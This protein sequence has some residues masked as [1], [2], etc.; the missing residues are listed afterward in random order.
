MRSFAVGGLRV[1]VFGGWGEIG[2]NQLLLEAG[3]E[4]ILLD[5]GRPFGRWKEYFTEFLAPRSAL[6][7]RDLLALGLLPRLRGLYRD[8]P[9]DTLFPTALERQLLD[10]APDAGH[11]QGLLLSH[12]HLDH[13]G[14]I[15]YLRADLPIYTTPET[16][17]ILKAMQD[18]GQAELDGEGVYIRL[19]RVEK[20]KEEEEEEKEEEG[21]EQ[22]KSVL[23]ADRWASYLRRP[24]RCLGGLPQG[25][26]E[27]SPA[28]RKG[29]E[30]H[31]WEAVD[32]PFQVGGFRVRAF[33]VDH[34]VPGAVAFAVETAEGLV[35][36]TGDLRFHGR[37]GSRA[38][39]FLR[40]LEGQKV[41]LLI[42]EGT[43]LG[44]P[45]GSRTEGAVKAALHEEIQKH[46]G[47]PVAVDFAPRN[48]ER[49]ESCLEV[50]RD[51]GR[52]L[53]V[54]PKD[55][56]LL[57]GLSEVDP[58]YKDVLGGVRVLQE[59]KA[60]TPGWE[61]RLKK[62][63]G[64]RRVTIEEVAKAPGSF[65]LALGFYEINRLLD[66]RLHIGPEP[67][68]LYIFSNSYW[69]DQEQILDLRVL[70]RW[71]SEL[72]FR[73]LPESLRG[74]PKDPMGV[75]NPYHTSGH[76]PEEELVEL[77]RCLRPRHL[78]P[79]HT[80]RPKRWKELLRGE[81]IRILL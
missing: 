45:G 24:Y 56:Y 62:A 70:N 81:R 63:P 69:A 75:D 46:P 65:L 20:V 76:A 14:A 6:G 5:F 23:T 27:L 8:G 42:V 29:I 54:T 28:K 64:L 48:V 25:F 33:P 18:T 3:G 51:L 11:V 66:L 77:V 79:V 17:V 26:H 55:A 22:E 39:A 71:L 50:A 31:P 13:S 72:N 68:G 57:W 58:R 40:A 1:H 30:G 15:A 60:Q 53:V 80:S 34:S 2:G 41:S 47:A 52:E 67:K 12:A 59:A 10:G 19:R 9:D 32:L 74:L 35:V 21:E 78:L 43:R 38:E 7:L 44:L 49:L 73:L 37:E 61:K 16:A 36:Y 4:A